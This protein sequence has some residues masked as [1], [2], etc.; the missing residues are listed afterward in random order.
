MSESETFSVN[1]VYH[2]FE[3]V[4][5]MEQNMRIYW[6]KIKKYCAYNQNLVPLPLDKFYS[7]MLYIWYTI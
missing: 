4:K 6:S 2:L 3:F 5:G 1:M 7:S